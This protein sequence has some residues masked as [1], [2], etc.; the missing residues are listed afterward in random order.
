M[1]KLA[2]LGQLPNSNSMEQSP[3]REA[4]CFSASQ[5]VPRILWNPKV[6]CHIHKSPLPLSL[7]SHINP[8]HALHLTSVRSILLFFHIRLGLQSGL[9]PSGYPTKTLYTSLLSLNTCYMPRQSHYSRFDHPNNIWVEYRSLISSLFSLLH[10][11]ITSILD[12]L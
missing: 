6:H 7:L 8:V 3:S 4:K 11:P 12:K 2:D 5:E 1:L 9:F 10:S